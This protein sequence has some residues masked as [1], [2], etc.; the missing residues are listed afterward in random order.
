MS[1]KNL[2]DLMLMMYVMEN[3]NI[4]GV[5]P[6]SKAYVWVESKPYISFRFRADINNED[7]ELETYIDVDVFY[8]YMEQ[9]HESIVRDSK[10][11]KLLI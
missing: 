1:V 2:E 5:R 4:S 10:L 9:T 11:D 6:L 3:P 7:L 8:P